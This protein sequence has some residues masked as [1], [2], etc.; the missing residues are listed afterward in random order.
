[1]KSIRKN[2]VMKEET[3]TAIVEVNKASFRFY[4]EIMFVVF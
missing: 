4:S 3:P 2:S 1:M